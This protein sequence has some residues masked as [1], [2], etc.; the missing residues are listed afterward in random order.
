[1]QEAN[2]VRPRWAFGDAAAGSAGVSQA[3]TASIPHS[4]SRSHWTAWDAPRRAHQRLRPLRLVPPRAGPSA[5][6]LHAAGS[7]SQPRHLGGRA[8]SM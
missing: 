3:T 1:M 7:K 2:T 5:I 6:G 4:F 8:C